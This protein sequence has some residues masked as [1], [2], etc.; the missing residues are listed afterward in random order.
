MRSLLI[1]LQGSSHFH[2]NLD[3]SLFETNYGIRE[4]FKLLSPTR[5]HPRFHDAL[6]H[7]ANKP[8]IALFRACLAIASGSNKAIAKC[9]KCF[10]KRKANLP[11]EKR[12]S[13]CLVM[14]LSEFYLLPI[15]RKGVDQ[16]IQFLNIT[17]TRRPSSN[18]KQ[19]AFQNHGMASCKVNN[20]FVPN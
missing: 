13:P 11:R 19:P 14:P 1:I 20:G 15:R 2:T 9:T 8:G 16:M 5:S 6:L 12:I 4:S 10:Q 17:F 7:M 18:E 3:T